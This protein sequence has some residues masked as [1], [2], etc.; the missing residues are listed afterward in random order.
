MFGAGVGDTNVPESA[1]GAGLAKILPA[2]GPPFSSVIE[3]GPTTELTRHS[4]ELKNWGTNSHSRQKLRQN[5]ALF[6]YIDK[7]LSIHGFIS[8][9]AN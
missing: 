4:A 2:M 9:D 5:A 7:Y 8:S 1:K 6:G 3:T